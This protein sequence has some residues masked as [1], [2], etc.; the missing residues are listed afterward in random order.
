MK[1]VFIERIAIDSGSLGTQD[2][3]TFRKSLENELGRLLESG[4]LPRGLTGA[5][6]IDGGELPASSSDSLPRAVA[7]QVV[8]SLGGQS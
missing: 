7:E 1:R 2:A 8:R 6:R 4:G 3:E 5:T